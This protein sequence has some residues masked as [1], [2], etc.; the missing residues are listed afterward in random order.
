[1]A[2]PSPL[3]GM[4]GWRKDCAPLKVSGCGVNDFYYYK[5]EGVDHFMSKYSKGDG[6]MKE[7]ECG[8]KCSKECK[9][10][11]YFY[12]TVS[13]R[14]WIAYELNTLTQVQNSTHLAYMKAPKKHVNRS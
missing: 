14:C 2:C 8:E 10:L 4:N 1:M 7:N 9:C 12:H 5:L 3:K 11:G 13:S 6:P